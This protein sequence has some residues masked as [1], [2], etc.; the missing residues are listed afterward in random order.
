M[1]GFESNTGLRFSAPPNEG[2]CTPN[3]SSNRLQLACTVLLQLKQ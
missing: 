3:L 1:K 2:C